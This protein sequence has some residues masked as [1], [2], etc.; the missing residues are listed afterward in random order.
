M[1]TTEAP[2]TPEQTPEHLQIEV[3]FQVRLCQGL[4]S[5]VTLIQLGINQSQLELINP[6]CIVNKFIQKKLA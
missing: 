6:Y 2:D 3:I 1:P 4:I 5:I